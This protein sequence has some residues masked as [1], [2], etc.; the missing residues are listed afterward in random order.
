ML[1]YP[2]ALIEPLGRHLLD[3]KANALLR[4]LTFT[5]SR[6]FPNSPWPAYF[7]MESY[8]S[9]DEERWQ[10]WRLKPMLKSIRERAELLPPSPSREQLLAN[11]DQ[12]EQQFKDLN[13]FSAMFDQFRDNFSGFG[14]DSFD[15]L[16][17]FGP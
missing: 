8:L 15:D 3:L 9:L 1:R 7:E 4:R 11:L 14:D 13:P 17:D 10:L 6:Q 5:W 12:R 2:E 16:E